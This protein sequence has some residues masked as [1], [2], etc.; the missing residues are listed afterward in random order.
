MLDCWKKTDKDIVDL[1]V[2]WDIDAYYCIVNNYKDKLIKYILRISNISLE[3]AENLLQEVFI[4]SYEKI[5]SYN[6]NYSFSSWIYRITHNTVIDY[7]RK[8]KNNIVVSIDNDDEEYKK[9]SNFLDSGINIELDMRNK[10]LVKKILEILNLL[11]DRYKEI[12]ILKFLEE[13][14]YDEISDILK[15]PTWTVATLINRWK[16]QFKQ[17]ALENNLDIYL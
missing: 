9:L 12:L 7:H 1:V 8:N 16:K 5:N 10:E 4:K 13:K 3:D 2:S 14:S 15:I 17:K 6:D 11:E